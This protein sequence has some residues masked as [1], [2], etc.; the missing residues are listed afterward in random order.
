MNKH[1]DRSNRLLHDMANEIKMLKDK[2][3]GTVSKLKNK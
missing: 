3:L 2:E 1:I